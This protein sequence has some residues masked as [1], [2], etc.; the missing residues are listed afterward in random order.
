MFRRDKE[1]TESSTIALYVNNVNC[2]LTFFVQSFFQLV[3]CIRR[4]STHL[5]RYTT[6]QEAFL[7]CPFSQCL[8][9]HPLNALPAHCSLLSV[10]T[11]GVRCLLC[12]D[13]SDNPRPGFGSLLQG[14]KALVQAHASKYL[15][16]HLSLKAAVLLPQR[17]LGRW[18]LLLAQRDI[19]LVAKFMFQL[20][21]F[22]N[23]GLREPS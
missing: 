5:T 10:A 23:I 8:L 13:Y 7:Q 20:R 6:Y 21:V 12:R 11:W 9:K 4:P 22:F 1:T 15:R 3:S 17:S 19:R 18:S 14:Y 16:H 2:F